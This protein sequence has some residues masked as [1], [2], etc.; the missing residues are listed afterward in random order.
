M[1]ENNIISLPVMDTSRNTCIGT[2]DV[3]DIASFIVSSFPSIDFLTNENLLKLEYAGNYIGTSVAVGDLLS[4]L[5]YKQ[6]H[7]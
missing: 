5:L 6:L 7:F 2:I 1:K 4:T 3:L